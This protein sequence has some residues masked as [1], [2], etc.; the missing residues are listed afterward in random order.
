MYKF[1][2]TLLLS[3]LWLLPA[4]AAEKQEAIPADPWHF[5]L[6][7]QPKKTEAEMGA[8]RWTTLMSSATGNYLFE[9]DSIKPVEDEKG[10]KSKSERQVLIRSI[11]KDARVLQQ[12]NKNYASKLATDENVAYCD[13]LLIFDL[14][15]QLYKTVQTQIYTK[16]GRLVEERSS[17]GIWKKVPGQSFADTL[18]KFLLND[19]KHK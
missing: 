15:K 13:M 4:C 10:N 8:E 5:E 7:M 6:S 3:C 2:A 17:E 16:A 1:F 19:D 9:Y 18:L 12:L 14:R 11:F